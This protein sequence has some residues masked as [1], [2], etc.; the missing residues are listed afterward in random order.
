MRLINADAL[1]GT[2]RDNHYALRSHMNTTG[3]GMFT[4]GI[5][6]AVDEQPTIDPVV[7]GEWLR[8][9]DWTDQCS[10]CG[11]WNEIDIENRTPYCANCG[12]KMDGGKA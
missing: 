7:H 3:N 8:A 12:A 9:D 6:Q 10:I 4:I 2:I 11:D 5:Q 1:M